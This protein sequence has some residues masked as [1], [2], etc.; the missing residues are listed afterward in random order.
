MVKK[1]KLSLGSVEGLRGLFVEISS[2]AVTVIYYINAN[3][4]M[5]AQL[6]GVNEL[7]FVRAETL[8]TRA[9]FVQCITL[10]IFSRKIF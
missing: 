5:F 6:L 4:N 7:S 9:I 8:D 3:D 1:D 10:I 2:R